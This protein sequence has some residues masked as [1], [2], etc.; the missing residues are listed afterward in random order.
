MDSG[1]TLLFYGNWSAYKNGMSKKNL[2]LE[3]SNVRP[4]KTTFA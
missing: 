2:T 4:Q 1:L 3:K